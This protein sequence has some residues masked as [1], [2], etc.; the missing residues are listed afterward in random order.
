MI[1]TK[2]E[3][4]FSKLLSID[5]NI[6]EKLKGC[7]CNKKK[8]K[9]LEGIDT[10]TFDDGTE[11][12]N[13]RNALHLAAINDDSSCTQLLL[14]AGSA[15]EIK[16]NDGAT[17]MRHAAYNQNCG[18]IMILLANKAKYKM[19]S[20]DLQATINECRVGKWCLFVTK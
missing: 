11:T 15:V 2:L 13:K 1:I 9:C 10:P 18:P 3:L 4:T 16:D 12:E 20:K 17:A 6:A 14:D 5:I 7:L 19:L 8:N